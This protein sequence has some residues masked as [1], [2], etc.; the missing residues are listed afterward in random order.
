[1]AWHKTLFST[2]K[3][4][5]SAI[6][7][8]ATVAKIA[9]KLDEIIKSWKPS[10]RN[11]WNGKKIAVLGPTAAGKN[12]LY[13]RLKGLPIPTE[14][15]QTRGAEKVDKFEFSFSL[16]NRKE[17]KISCKRAVNVGGERDERDRYWFH[18]C[19]NADIVFYLLTVDDLKAGR[20]EPGSRIH[21][22]FEWLASKLPKMTSHVLVHILVNK[23]DLIFTSDRTYKDIDADLQP[24]LQELERS[25]RSAF[26]PYQD[27]LTGA[28]PTS[29]KNDHLFAVSFSLAL[30]AV[31]DTVNQ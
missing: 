5:G 18:A 4:I 11:W 7:A 25:A 26:G 20:F 6:A 8:V 10:V 28:T 21:N 14:H 31:Y 16:P 30:Q 15:A 23:I 13:N 2:I 3:T 1:M 17:F 24:A 9:Q 12:S 29:M 22:D 19:D 27:R